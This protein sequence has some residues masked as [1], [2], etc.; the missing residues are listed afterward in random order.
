MGSVPR[1]YTFRSH[2]WYIIP[3]PSTDVSE[4]GG[5]QSYRAGTFTFFVSTLPK[6]AY[7]IRK[8]VCTLTRDAEPR[9]EYKF[10][11]DA[12]LIVEGHTAILMFGKD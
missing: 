1:W 6:P 9:A 5:K 3:C 8:V 7:R 12:R 10:G 2:Y 11:P 4:I